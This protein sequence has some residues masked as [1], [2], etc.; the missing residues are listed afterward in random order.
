MISAT[1]RHISGIISS[2][3]ARPAG[4]LFY[5]MIAAMVQWEREEIAE[6]IAASV[7]VH[8]KMGRHLGGAA[9]FG[10]QWKDSSLPILRKYRSENSSTSSSA[11]IEERRLLPVS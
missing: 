8:A 2:K 10:Y 5:T 3:L 11:S 6:R 9:P 4:C 7:P 1:D